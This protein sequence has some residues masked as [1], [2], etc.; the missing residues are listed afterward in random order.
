MA[1]QN[2]NASHDHQLNEE[3]TTLAR[4][5]GVT[6]LAEDDS[7]QNLDTSA[8]DEGLDQ[9]LMS[10]RQLES[11]IE[12]AQ[13]ATGYTPSDNKVLSETASAEAGVTTGIR[14]QASTRGTTSASTT[15]TQTATAE[16][17]ES[18]QAVEA[19]N[20]IQNKGLAG[21]VGEGNLAAPAA[22]AAFSAATTTTPEAP[23]PVEN[24]EVTTD[25]P[26]TTEEAVTEE[27]TENSETPTPSTPVTEP[28]P[29][30]TP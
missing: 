20:P 30:P 11:S 22:A 8:R 16:H 27:T 7:T 13:L 19:N 14:A 24:V 6:N 21:E 15:N 23:A 9:I 28:T 10:K 17:T 29:A 25:T 4:D 5:V 3:L 26:A 2:D 12:M 1:E 18:A